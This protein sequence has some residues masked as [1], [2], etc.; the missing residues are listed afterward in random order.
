[1][2]K[3]VAQPHSLSQSN[4]II[5]IDGIN[6]FNN[7]NEEF[8]KKQ[9]KDADEVQ[10]LVLEESALK[11]YQSQNIDVSGEMDGIIYKRILKCAVDKAAPME[12]NPNGIGSL[13]RQRQSSTRLW[14]PKPKL[15]QT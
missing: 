1:M 2:R 13:A 9:P 3:C 15:R 12:R 6:V 5:E 4:W 8:K 10:L 7:R 14:L 11:Y